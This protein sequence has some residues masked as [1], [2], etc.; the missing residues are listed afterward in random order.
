MS[1]TSSSAAEN[2]VLAV[3]GSG[4]AR[5]RRE[6]S[7]ILSLSA[8]TVSQHVQS[9][10]AQGLI[11]EGDP[12]GSTGGRRARELRLSG[13][14]DL[15]GAIDL[16][17]AHARLTVV[18]RGGAVSSTTEIPI[19][20]SDGPRAVLENCAGELARLANGA[21]LAGVGIALPGPVDVAARGVVSPS[22]MPGWAGSDIPQ[23]LS[24]IVGAP[25]VVE[26]DANAMALGEHFAHDPRA[27]GSV[28]I[29]AGTAI[30]AGIVIDGE[31]YRGAAGVAGDITHTRVAAARDRQCSCGNRGCLE[32]VASGAALVRLLREEGVDVSTTTE[33]VALVRDADP[34]ATRLARAAGNHLG[35]V[36]CAVVNFFN[37]SAIYI[38]GALTA[39]EPFMSALRSEVY[40]GSHPL[41]TRDL[42]IAP[43]ALGA[44]AALVGAA[45]EVNEHLARLTQG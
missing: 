13:D 31:V 30:G 21:P 1:R 45:R 28:T 41:M 5:S 43:A 18:P 4:R 26:N 9:L 37:P 35:E 29:K 23:L 15:I 38:G 12:R 22:R 11:E 33:V 39:L 24:D 10:L 19:T 27:T 17:G 6:V 40:E 44:D 20:M 2:Q 14:A 8:S 25:A 3:V 42:T 34:L 36:L 16:G 7:Q 32:T